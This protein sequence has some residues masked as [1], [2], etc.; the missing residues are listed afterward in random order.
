MGVYTRP[1]RGVQGMSIRNFHSLDLSGLVRMIQQQSH[2]L[3]FDMSCTDDDDDQWTCSPNSWRSP[4][5]FTM[6]A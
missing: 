6:C 4:I 2:A 1:S 3:Q 5:D